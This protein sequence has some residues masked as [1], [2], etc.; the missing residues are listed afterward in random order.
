MVAQKRG[1]AETANGRGA[2][3]QRQLSLWQPSHLTAGDEDSTLVVLTQP[4]Q[5]EEW[6][7]QRISKG[8]RELRVGCELETRNCRLWVPGESQMLLCLTFKHIRAQLRV[9]TLPTAKA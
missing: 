4:G 1:K 7:K 9:V 5:E 3:Q 8:G 6:C 2:V